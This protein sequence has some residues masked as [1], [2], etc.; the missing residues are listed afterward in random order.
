MNGQETFLTLF[1]V[2]FT[3]E[4]HSAVTVMACFKFDISDDRTVLPYF[5]RLQNRADAA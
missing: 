5:H 3:Q 4:S 1:I 2:L